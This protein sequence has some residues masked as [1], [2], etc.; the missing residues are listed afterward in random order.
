[1]NDEPFVATLTVPSRTASVRVAAGFFVETARGLGVPAADNRLFEVAV[2]EALNN[3]V[4][5]NV[6]HDETSIRCELALTGRRLT[7]T[8]LDDGARAPIALTL[9]V[10]APIWPEPSADSWETIPESGYGLY[11][12][13]AV[14]PEVRA[15]SRNGIHGIEMALTF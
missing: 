7:I 15:V 10:G 6:R 3:A 12:M 1:V 4:R 9:P 5:H 14:F 8:V 13:Q 2:V 11:L